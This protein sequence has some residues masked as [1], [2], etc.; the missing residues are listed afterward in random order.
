MTA[1]HVVATY[2]PERL[3]VYQTD[4]A[5][6][7]LTIRDFYRINAGEPDGETEDLLVFEVDVSAKASSCIAIDS[8]P[9]AW[10]EFAHTA[11][12]FLIGYPEPKT[13]VDY[14]ASVI[15]SGQVLLAGRYG[16]PASGAPYC[17]ELS[18]ENPLLLSTFS[19]FSGGPVFSL[20]ERLAAPPVL[21]LCGMALQGTPQSGV[22]RFLDC[23][24]LQAAMDEVHQPKHL[25]RAYT[26][27]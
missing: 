16:K 7:P 18:V 5:R 25:R 26:D 15:H 22:V 6:S 14:D 1:K 10:H 17:H 27:A 19:G 11:Q 9:N 21:R 20:S 12:Y 3:R 23:T 8:V 24:V 2:P 13:Y 4:S